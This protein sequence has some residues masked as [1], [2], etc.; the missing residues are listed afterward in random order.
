MTTQVFGPSG[1]RLAHSTTLRTLSVEGPCAIT[2]AGQA[3]DYLDELA[4]LRARGGRAGALIDALLSTLDE[5]VRALPREDASFFTEG[6]DARRWITEPGARPTTQYLAAVPVSFPLIFVAQLAHYERLRDS[7]LSSVSPDFVKVAAGHSQGIM[8]AVCASITGLSGDLL[9]AAKVFAPLGLMFALRMQQAWPVRE[10]KPGAVASAQRAGQEPPSA[11]ASVT[12][13]LAAELDALLQKFGSGIECTL[14]NTLFRQVLSAEPE[15]LEA[16]RLQL[17]AHAQEQHKARK[18]RRTGGRVLDPQWQYLPVSAPFHSR[19]MAPAMERLYQDAKS[20]GFRWSTRDLQIPVLDTERAVALS[21]DDDLLERLV[22]LQCVRPVRWRAMCDAIANTGAKA[23]LDC[24]PGDALSKLTHSNLRG[25]G[26]S[27]WPLSAERTLSALTSGERARSEHAVEYPQPRRVGDRVENAWTKLTRTPPI[28]LAGMTPT[29]VEAP[30]VAAA[31]NA[32]FTAELAGGGQVT[33]AI[34]RLRLQELSESL[35]PGRSIVFNTL[36]LDPYLWKLHMGGPKPLIVRLAEEGFA[37]TG[38]TVSAGVPAKE[39]AVALWRTLNRAGLRVNALKPGNDREIKEA[40]AIAAAVPELTVI[41]QIEGGH[42]GGHHSW[43]DLDDLLLRHYPALRAHSNVIVAVGGGVGTPERAAQYIDGT[44]AI[45]YGSRPLPVDCVFIGT[46]AMAC[47]EAMTS[48]SVKRALVAAKGTDRWVA[49][50]SF[51]SGVT[52]GRSQL[53]ASVYYLDTSAARAGRLLDRVAGDEKAV[54]AHRAEIIAALQ[55]TARP[56]FGDVESMTYSQWLTRLCE[57]TAIGRGGRYEDGPWP[58][59]SY[60]HRMLEA[61]RMAEARLHDGDEPFASRFDESDLDQPMA[62]LERLARELPAAS[63]ER[64][65]PEDALAFF[66]LCRTAGKPVNFVPK[67][68]ADVRRWFKADSLWAAHDDRFEADQ[69]L[70][71]PGPRALAA[72]ERVDEPVGSLLGR[73]SAGILARVRETKSSVASGSTNTFVATLADVAAGERWIT[74]LASLDDGPVCAM[75]DAPRAFDTSANGAVKTTLNPLRTLLAPEDGARVTVARGP[76]GRVSFLRTEDSDGRVRLTVTSDRC[77]LRSYGPEG[78]EASLDL[79]LSWSERGHLA[80]DRA[81]YLRGQREFYQRMLFGRTLPEVPAFEA[82]QGSLTVTRTMIEAF[83]YATGDEPGRL[84]AHGARA[85]API[86]MAFA[87]LWEPMFSALSGAQPDVAR[88]V[89]EELDVEARE[90]WPICD[91]DSLTIRA[92]ITALDRAHEGTR[93]SIEGTLDKAD[94]A[95][96]AIVRSTF[97]IRESNAETARDHREALPF[98][99]RI[100]LRDEVSLALLT[101]QRWLAFE[102]KPAVGATLV[103]RC[104]T[105]THE[106]A[107]ARATGSIETLDGARIASV[108]CDEREC[109]KEHPVRALCALLAERSRAN[110]LAAPR[111]L[112]A[113]SATAPRSMEAYALASGDRN[114]LH[115]DRAVATLADMPAPIVHGMWTASVAAHRAQ[116]AAQCPA[117]AVRR[118]TARFEAPVSLGETLDISVDQRALEDGAPSLTTV[119]RARE[120][121]T[122]VVARATVELAAPRTAYVFPGQGIQRAAMGMNGYARSPAARLVWDT[123]DAHCRKALGFSLLRVVRENPTELT[124]RKERFA[125]PQGVLFLTQFTQVAMVVL[126][127]AQVAELRAQGALVPDAMFAGHSLGEYSALTAIAAVV[128]LQAAIEVVYQRGLTMDRLVPR[129]ESGR[130]PYAMRVIRPNLVGLDDSA[131]RALVDSCARPD[132]PLEIVNFNVRGRQYSVTGHTRALDRLEATIVARA[133]ENNARRALVVV[134]GVD[135]PFHSTLLRDGVDRFRQTLERAFPAELDARPLVG[136]YVPNLTGRLFSLE[137][138]ELERIVADTRS[139]PLAALLADWHERPTAE[140][141]RQRSRTVLIELLA[142]QFASPVRWIETQELL[143]TQRALDRCIEVGIAEQ[144]TLMNM[145]NLS[146]AALGV[147]SVRAM[148]SELHASECLGPAPIN[149]STTTSAPA[150][151]AKAPAATQAKPAAHAPVAMPAASAVASKPAEDLAFTVRDGLRALLALQAKVRL[152]QLRDDESIDELLGGN[153]ARRNQVLADVAQEFGVNA[154]DGAHELPLRALADTLAMRATAYSDFGKYLSAAVEQ[155][156]GAA[157]AAARTSKSDAIEHLSAHWGLGAGRTRHV[158]ALM[159]LEA[160]SGDSTRGG[161]LSTRPPEKLTDRASAT[162]WIDAIVSA[163]GALTGASLAPVSARGAGSVA[164]DSAALDALEARVFG[165][166]GALAR[167]GAT[168][169]RAAGI[170]PT[171]TIEPAAIDPVRAQLD[172]IE[173]E[174]GRHDEPYLTLTRPVFSADKH[175]ALTSE[176]VWLR[177]DLAQAFYDLLAGD[178]ADRALALVEHRV[179]SPQSRAV[180]RA[181]AARAKNLG[182]DDVAHTLEALASREQRPSEH[183]GRVALVTGAGPGS[184]ALAMVEK[185]LSQGARV[186]VTTSRYS[187]DRLDALRAMYAERARMGAELHVVPM[188]QGSFEDVD[189]LVQWLANNGLL[190]ELLLPFGALAENATLLDVGP[191]SLAT[192]RIQLVG[193]QR[194][195]AKLSARFATNDDAMARC[196]CVLPLSPNHGIFGGDGLYGESKAALEVLL[197][198]W[199]SEQHAWGRFF[200]LVGAR[201]GWVRGTGLMAAN[202]VLAETLERDYGLRTWDTDE[203]ANELIALCS[204][205]V[206]EQCE[207]EP[208]L[209]DLTAGFDTIR[210]LGSIANNVRSAAENK[211]RHEAAVRALR[212]Q[213]AERVERPAPARRPMIAP[214]LRP[215]VTAAMPSDEELR[216]LPTLDHLDLDRVAVVVGYG[217]VSPWGSARTRWAAEKSESLSLEALRELAWMTGLVEC[218]AAGMLVDKETKK[219]VTARDLRETYLPRIDER[220]GIRLVKGPALHGF[221]PANQRQHT[222]VVVDEPLCFTAA[223]V[224]QAER[225]RSADPEHVEL[226]S[227]DGGAIRVRCKRGARVRVHTHTS[228]RRRVVGQVPDG[229]DPL[230]YGIS[231]SMVEQVDRTTLYNLVATVEAFLA[232]G[233]EPEELY[234]HLHITRVATTQS[235]GIGGMQKLRRLYHDPLLDRERQSDVLQETLINVISGWMVQAYVGSYGPISSPVGACATAALSIAEALDMLATGRADFVVTGGADDYNEEGAVGFSDMGATADSID[236]E[237]K[238]ISPRKLSRP[239]DRRRMGFVEAQGAGALLVC[240]ASLAL[241]MGLPVYGIVSYAT[242]HS[243]G[244][245]ASVP[246]PGQGILGVA[247][248]SK[249]GHERRANQCQFAERRSASLALEGQRASLVS[250]LGQSAADRVIR[251]GR[252]HLGHTFFRDDSAI[253]P[254]RGSLAVFGLDGDDVAFVSKHDT[255]TNANDSNESK[256]HARLARQLDRTEHLPLPVISQK[257]LTGH[258]KGAAAAWQI[259]GALQ[260]MHDGVIP[261]NRSLEDV[262][263]NLRE[264]EPLAFSDRNVRARSTILRAALVTSLGFGHVGAIVC[265]IHPHF[266]WRML[267]NEQRQSYR[268]RAN[269]RLELATTKLRRVL[270]GTQPLFT[271]RSDRPFV[272]KESSD[273][274]H[275]HEAETLLDADARRRSARFESHSHRHS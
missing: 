135:V 24:G 150:V 190:P 218:D 87:L 143:F 159:A 43:E 110:V 73:F 84:S 90:A 148:N 35:E 189:A 266:F 7:G 85:T 145:A 225:F 32:G 65:H 66:A 251:E 178:P 265:V 122:R 128:P 112:F 152:D 172:A 42:A 58:D 4:N 146:L 245:N 192:L 173:R 165:A 20:L 10:P 127:V 77:T 155:R 244:I 36:Y 74:K 195:I 177:R 111:A 124:V 119:V 140:T 224:E 273:A 176:P 238:G 226:E 191:R 158:L 194:L 8:A 185:L 50:G 255:S 55:K 123:A 2:F 11:M 139:K 9:P 141:L 259:I 52:S 1:A 25:T 237:S 64:V 130:T 234:E 230:R 28:V 133:G 48:P 26:I 208:L 98:E 136:R 88:L 246:A 72:I 86:A 51:D 41:V 160:R 149:A 129:D 242:S 219:R 30:I 6:M 105:M 21:L 153:S 125:H 156:I 120:D 131:L 161:S 116:H 267:T 249:Q 18:E 82:A 13:L 200:T 47:L 75:I 89:H 271:R 264:I 260:A 193:V 151:E 68:D 261:A 252:A 39:E 164:V 59:R 169:L 118:L 61:L 239:N 223:N 275:Q 211:R 113:T 175:M 184:I 272:D 142:Y 257:S 232:A 213:L 27:I 221:D 71:L 121:E 202:D 235:S 12:G 263:P 210:D 216:A 183:Q 209:S 138:E 253:S 247:A 248:E 3:S 227:L 16:F 78:R 63:S 33:E 258:S 56:Y 243:D 204:E 220:S 262:A 166:D 207:R 270:A 171:D 236:A 196:H 233:M 34:L 222:E 60:R 70:A 57:L 92:A 80:H 99:R 15:R 268:A 93:V 94:G 107:R 100:E 134:P 215:R 188:N 14:D 206:R 181:L 203:M 23:I 91:G 154:I 49:D 198:R 37:I 199:K 104:A 217:E 269:A 170:E 229:W 83:A 109:P 95:R 114:P 76:D 101:E 182:R 106:G 187:D 179:D 254:L 162:Q 54:Q 132:E 103:V 167:A 38:V 62:V 19:A 53:D 115:L 79:A 44:W 22:T 180:A 256:L 45:A 274:H 108:L 205:R 174:H 40:L 29:T 163:H 96:A 69:V 81:Q 241:S 97:F 46:A 250:A 168:L 212:A 144:P 197:A 17:V 67:I 137:R 201:I 31:A 231:K 117:S 147:D 102:S 214:T 126:A 5:F 157:L 228:L 186:V 240:R